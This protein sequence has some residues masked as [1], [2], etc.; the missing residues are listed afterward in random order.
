MTDQAVPLEA[1]PEKIVPQGNAGPRRLQPLRRLVPFILAYPVRLTLTV[2]TMDGRR[3]EK[4][5]VQVAP[6]SAEE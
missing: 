4:I 6:P 1:D 5:H 3:I 2:L